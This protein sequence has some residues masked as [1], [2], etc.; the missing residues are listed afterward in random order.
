MLHRVLH[1]T[2]CWLSHWTGSHALTGS[3]PVERTGKHWRVGRLRVYAA[4]GHVHAHAFKSGDS[5]LH[6]VTCMPMQS[7]VATTMQQGHT[8]EPAISPV[9]WKTGPLGPTAVAA[10]WL[11]VHYMADSAS[12]A[13]VRL[14][15]AVHAAA[16]PADGKISVMTPVIDKQRDLNIQ[17]KRCCDVRT[18]RCMHRY[19]NVI[20]TK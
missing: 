20:G 16:A 11:T 1:G 6:M 15:L 18:G 10:L 2:L 4:H 9:A 13:A 17:W 8:G 14:L 12:G 19:C 5:M 3:M 7:R